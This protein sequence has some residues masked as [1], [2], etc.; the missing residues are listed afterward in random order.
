MSILIPTKIT[1]LTEKIELV[2]MNKVRQ[3]D[4]S[5][6]YEPEQRSLG[7]YVSFQ[8]SYESLF[9]GFEHPGPEWQKGR[10]VDIIIRPR[11]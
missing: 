9:L 11:E 5:D 6:K 10:E 8:G 3:P 2:R 1:A 7:W 4:G